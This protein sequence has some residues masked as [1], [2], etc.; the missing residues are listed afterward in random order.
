MQAISPLPIQ[1]HNS[2]NHLL[3]HLNQLK[4]A[5]LPG[6]G[7]QFLFRGEARLHPDEHGRATVR[8][9]FH[10]LQV[11]GNLVGQAFTIYRHARQIVGASAGYKVSHED[12]IAVLRHYEL[13]TPSIDVTGTPAV[14]LSFALGSTGISI[15]NDRFVFVVDVTKLPCEDEQNGRDEFKVTVEDHFFLTQP[16]S[17]GGLTSRWMRQDGFALMP[18]WWRAAGP[19]FDMLDKR[20][21]NALTLHSFPADTCP[22]LPMPNL[23]SKANDQ[24]AVRVGTAV[25]AFVAAQGWIVHPYLAKIIVQI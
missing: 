2:Y 19:A 11:D 9:T 20:M 21:L 8:S 14:A 13:P 24:V 6:G 18:S 5:C 16:I 15:S 3:T 1:H 22:G 17:S 23:M 25:R 12:A 10:R 7:Q 4:T